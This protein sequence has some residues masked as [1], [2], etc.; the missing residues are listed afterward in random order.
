[1]IIGITKRLK[2]R[3]IPPRA[4]SQQK[5]PLTNLIQTGRRLCQQRGLAKRRASHRRP[6]LDAR[7]NRGQSAQK[8]EGFPEAALL[9]ARGAPEQMVSQPERIKAHL[10]G[11]LHN[12]S[13]VG[14][15]Q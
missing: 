8:G 10:L 6:K 1:M 14:E 13:K 15:T 11:S 2:L 7:G 5:A 12:V 9:L 3:L 4:E